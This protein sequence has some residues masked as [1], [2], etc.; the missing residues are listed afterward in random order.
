LRILP[1]MRQ[2]YLSLFCGTIVFLFATC[3]KD[4]LKFHSVQKM[5]SN[6][7][8]RLNHVRF[9]SPTTVIAAG[10][11]QFYQ[12]EI[13]ISHDGGYTWSSFSDPAAPKEMFGMAVTSFNK[14]VLCGVDGDVLTSAD[15]GSTWKFN[16]IQ[17]WSQYM[18]GT[19]ITQDTGI[20]VSTVLQRQCSITRID[21]SFKTIDAQ[22]YTFGANNIYF[23]SKDTGYLIGYGTVMKTTDRGNTW[24]FLDVQDDNFMSLCFINDTIK[25]CGYNGSIYSSSDGGNSWTMLRNGNDFTIP[26]HGLL[27]IMFSDSLHGWIACDDGTLL[28]SNDGGNHWSEFETFTSEAIRS[29]AL[30][31][32]NDI[33]A[34]GDNGNIYRITP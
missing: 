6:T 14:I 19:F 23:R 17:D 15:S 9:I 33:L 12:S 2:R 34:V 32:N 27:D 25:M 4:Q 29:F 5:V 20:F 11:I 18:S 8:C 28:Y 22:T 24:N 1:C 13:V 10:G 26:H 31:P 21:S 3:K 30:C 16:R 7:N